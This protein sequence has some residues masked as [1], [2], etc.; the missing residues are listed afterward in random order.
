MANYNTARKGSLVL[1]PP[2]TLQ[3]KML[4]LNAGIGQNLLT[5]T[6]SLHVA[7]GVTGIT[8]KFTKSFKQLGIIWFLGVKGYN[9]IAVIIVRRLFRTWV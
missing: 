5:Q 1:S 9:R 3:N 6:K 2:L 7:F 4:V 8:N